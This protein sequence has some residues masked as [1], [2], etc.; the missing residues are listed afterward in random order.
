[1]QGIF[2]YALAHLVVLGHLWKG[3]WEPPGVHPGVYAVFAF[4]LLSGY[5]MALTLTRTYSFDLRGIARFYGNRALRIYPPYLVVVAATALV[6]VVAPPR[7]LVLN[8]FLRLP[9]S[10]TGWLH[11]LAIFGL[12]TDFFSARGGELHRLVPP[13][14]SL[15]VE[16]CF[17]LLMGAVLG[18]SRIVA[19]VWLLASVAY[20]M[21][22][23]GSGGFWAGRYTPPAAA[24]LP[25]SLGACIYHWRDPLLR[26]QRT[27]LGAAM[28]ALGARGDPE[29]W[30]A[31]QAFGVGALFLLHVLLAERVWGHPMYGGF[32]LSL[33]LAACLL[34]CLAALDPKRLPTRL[35]RL[36][37]FLGEL[38]YPVFLCHWLAALLAAWL[39]LD[40]VPTRG[41]ALFWIS[42]IPI[43]LLAWALRS[44]VERPVERVRDR[45][46]P[47][48]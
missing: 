10:G 4:Y 42:L 24:S 7:V 45:L 16:L 47:R 27:A 5:L 18:R 43:N 37:R 39:L 12:G 31:W 9:D 6:L 14:W 26:A 28:R 25:F 3:W 22:L 44:A 21:H 15:E 30:L 11:N 8:S 13:A 34:L 46:R 20:T 41:P 2:R 40:A 23:L 1:M 36:D 29:A 19:G 38:S 35:V 33:A 32:Y 48:A 17:Y